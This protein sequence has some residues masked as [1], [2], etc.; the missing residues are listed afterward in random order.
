[1]FKLMRKVSLNNKCI[2]SANIYS[3]L[4][5]VL[6]FV[7]IIIKTELNMLSIHNIINYSLNVFLMNKNQS[8]L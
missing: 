3:I 7:S 6:I 5:L 4:Y 1:M 8:K 2:A